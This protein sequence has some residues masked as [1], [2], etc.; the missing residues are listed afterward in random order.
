MKSVT[1]LIF[2][3]NLRI[4]FNPCINRALDHGQLIIPILFTDHDY[5]NSI[6]SVSKLWFQK[7]VKDLNNTLFGYGGRLIISKLPPL[8]PY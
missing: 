2:N 6:G 4:N 1:I 7:A 5:L 3:R 8:T